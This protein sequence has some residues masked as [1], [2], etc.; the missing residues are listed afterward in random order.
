MPDIVKIIYNHAD[1]FAPQPTPLVG[2]AEDTIYVGERW[3]VRENVTLNGQ[4]TGCTFGDIVTGQINLLSRFNKSFQSLEVWQQTG[5]LSGL[6]YQKDFV[7]VQSIEFA[8]NRMVG[9]LP[10]VVNLSCYPSGLFSGMFGVLEPSDEWSYQEQQNATLNVTHRI[11]CRGINT[12]SG[13]SNALVN[14]RTWAFGRTGISST[15]QPIFISGVNSGTFCLLSLNETIDR[16]NGTYTLTE[17][18]INDLA[19]TGYD[20]I[21]YTT[22]IDSG[23]N[24]MSVRLA[25]T[26]EGCGQNI[27][28]AR[29]AFANINMPAV[30]AKSYSYTFG[31]TNLNPIPLT[32]SFTEDPFN[33][34]ISFDYSFN[35]DNSP[36]ISFDYVVGLSVGTNGF[37]TATIQGTVRARGGTLPSKLA[38][39]QTYAATVSL[40]NLVLPFYNTFDASSIVPLNPVATTQGQANNQS[41][42]TV[43]LNATY[44]NEVK[45]SDVLDRFDYTL[46]FLKA[47]EKVDSKPILGGLGNY[48]LVDLGYANRAALSING[49]AVVNSNYS[50]DAGVAAVKSKAIALLAQYGRF[51]AIALDQNSVTT[52]RFDDK[53]LSFAFSWSFDGTIIGPTTVGTLTI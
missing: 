42:G 9:V 46:N 50:S 36:E 1:A 47:V 17:N 51:G 3:A 40:Y 34:T 10:Y 48:S 30:A 8:P 16:F 26:V 24:L 33:S 12:S 37:I 29:N 2:I 39:T 14:A 18:Y 11:A 6:V 13:P 32:Q 4:I 45:A 43:E 28:G 7:E 44:T 31:M 49:N 5:I 38:R 53:V 23:S 21:R 19:R 41:D 20:V 22:T 35:N 15:I 27:T 25:G 52:N